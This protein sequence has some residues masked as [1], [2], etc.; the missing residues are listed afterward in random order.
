MK[1]NSIRT[2]TLA[3]LIM[4]SGFSV[5]ASEGEAASIEQ[6]YSKNENLVSV[7]SLF[8]ETPVSAVGEQIVYPGGTPAEIS[9]VHITIP[10]GHKTSWHKHG[11]PLFIYVLSG[12]L[13]VDYAE[14]GM[15]TVEAGS[16]F[17]EAM[18]HRHRGINNGTDPVEV[19]AVY[20]GAKDAENVI[21]D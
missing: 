15:R 19:L 17:M 9:A 6:A 16:A 4:L 10:P 2:L 7:R 1:T 13:E 12:V 14:K 11:V 21:G 18:D 8:A 5:R 20:M 3:A